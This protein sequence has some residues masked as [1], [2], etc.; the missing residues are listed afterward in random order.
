MRDTAH[1]DVKRVRG[2]DHFKTPT[3]ARFPRCFMGA[4]FILLLFAGHSG[5]LFAESFDSIKDGQR[6]KFD[7]V[8]PRGNDFDKL[9]GPRDALLIADS[10]GRV[11]WSK[12]ADKTLVPASTLKLLTSLAALHYLGPGY[13]FSTEFYLDRNSNLKIK[14]YGDPLLISEVLA[15]IAGV[16]RK[17]I[18]TYNDLILDDSY[19]AGPLTIPG[20]TSSDQPYDAPNGALCV[21]FNTIFFEREK[22]FPVSAEPQTPLLP[23]ALKRIGKSSRGQGRIPLS[24]KNDESLLYAGHLFRY[25]LD[26]HGITSGGMIKTGEVNPATD[27]LVYRYVSRF[28]LEENIAKLLEHSNNFMANQLL[29]ATGAKVGGPP[30]TLD[31]GVQT[32]ANFSKNVLKINQIKMVEGSGI[33]RKNRISVQGMHKVLDAFAPFRHLLRTRDGFQYKSGTLHHVSTAAGYFEG[34][35]KELYRIV[36]LLNSPGKSARQVMEKATSRLNLGR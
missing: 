31:K 23:F 19:F 22:G 34:G 30:G 11:L 6:K 1:N 33:S 7:G 18:S 10:R 35:N 24:R 26:R 15:D 14:G 9:L 13:R 16:L 17:K 25:F 3:F 12:N 4:V 32:M 20:I 5:A 21:N 8:K 36:V 29:I 2:R 27:Q 28:S